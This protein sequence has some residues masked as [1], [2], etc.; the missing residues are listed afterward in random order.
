VHPKILTLI[1]FFL[2]FIPTAFARVTM[3]CK[4]DKRTDTYDCEFTEFNITID[5]IKKAKE[6]GYQKGG[7]NIYGTEYYPGEHARIY[8]Q[9]LDEYG[10]PIDNG[11]CVLNIYTPQNSKLVTNAT[12]P[13]LENGL[14]YYDLIAPSQE[15][16]YMLTVKCTWLLASSYEYVDAFNLTYGTESGSY[17]NTY[18]FDGVYHSITEQN[19][20]GSYR[21][22]FLYIFN[23][24]NIPNN[25]N[26]LSLV[27]RGSWKD[28]KENV[29]ICLYNFRT[30]SYDCIPNQIKS[31][32]PMVSYETTN[33]QDY[34]SNNQVIVKFVDTVQVGDNVASTLDTDQFYISLNYFFPRYINNIRGGGEMHVHYP[35]AFGGLTAE[36][37]WKKYLELYPYIK[38]V[39]KLTDPSVCIDNQTLLHYQNYTFCIADDCRLVTYNTTEYCEY[40]CDPVLNRC[41][42]K[43]LERYIIYLLVLIVLTIIGGLVW[44]LLT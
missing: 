3:M 18:E 22:E 10:N 33:W 36:E 40:G 9:L 12:M 21:L 13:F 1:L 39:T 2:L 31:T 20:N 6:V 24:V 28:K 11:N 15:G 35:P 38:Y 5:E 19:V 37:V 43:P 42:P 17:L 7:I 32:T 23:N 29:A 27:W 25:T 16:V 26:S 8:V 30:S 34:I 41:M 44:K 14:Y 4:Y